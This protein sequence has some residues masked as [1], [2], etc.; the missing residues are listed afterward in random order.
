[1]TAA[2]A[3]SGEFV[4]FDRD[5]GVGLVDAVGAS[6]AVPGVWPPVTIGDRRYIDGGIRSAT[7]ADL[8]AGADRVVVIAPVNAGGGPIRRLAG[9]VAALR[10][11]AAVAVVRPDR[12]ARRAIGRNALDPARRAPAARA[13]RAQAATVAAAVAQVWHRTG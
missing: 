8:A 6:C 1:V 3:V 11:T 13:G 5:T 2:D 4:A 9:Q 10:R 12:A 7:N